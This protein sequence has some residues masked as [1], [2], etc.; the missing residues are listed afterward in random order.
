MFLSNA[1][2]KRPVAM[3]CLLIGLALLG[4]N[5][6]RKLGLELMPALDAPFITV[7][8]LYPGASPGQIEV[9]V[10][11]PIEDA[12]VAIDGLKHVSS[13]CME[14]ICLT[15][16][17][18]ELEVDVDIAATD[19]REKIDLIRNDF[20]EDVED[21][22][23][24]KYDFNSKPVVQL[25]LTGDVP[26]D[27]L[28]DYAD[29]TLKDRLTVLPGVA[30]A[31]LIGGAE[32]EVQVLLDR[33]KLAA[34]NLASSQILE[35]VGRAVGT[36]PSGRIRDGVEEYSVEFDADVARP[37]DLEHLEIIN[38]DGRRCYVRDVARV[39][40]FTEEL[41]Q[42][43]TIDGRPCIAIKVVK[44]SDANAVRVV[45]RV[46]GAMDKLNAELPGGME[47]I[48]VQDDGRF[49]EASVN[50]AWKNVL[51][52]IALTAL[53]LLLF[54]YNVRATLVVA[55]T[56]PL[57][58]VI[59]LFFMQAIGY[60]LNTS[61]LI[62]VGLSVGVL[63]TNS[64]VVL[65]AIVKRLNE[66]GDPKEAARLGAKE[67]SV[68]VL[69]SV[70]TNIVVLF[71]IALMGGMVGQ[72]LSPLAMTMVVMTAV[73]LFISFTL[74]PLLCSLLLKPENGASRSPLKRMERL[75][76]RMF[77][78]VIAAY[79]WGLRLAMRRRWAAAL[80]VVIV[81]ALSL[82]SLPMAKGAGFSL[83]GDT[84]MGQ[85]LV[86]LEFPTR[87][88]LTE[89]TRRVGE[90]EGSLSTLPELEHVLTSIGRVEGVVGQS[91]EGVYLAQ[92]LLKLTERDERSL[93]IDDLKDQVRQ[94]LTS[95]PDCIRTVST[96]SIIGGQDSSIQLQILGDDLDTLDGLALQAAEFAR[97]IPG[98][99]DADTTVRIGKP[100][101]RVTPDRAVLGDLD[102]PA[103]AVGLALRANVEGMEAGTFKERAR[104]Y[105]IVVKFDERQ[106]KGQVDE[107]LFPA[108]G[109]RRLLLD[110]LGQTEQTLA[111]VQI[112]REDKRRCAK[113]LGDNDAS[114]PLGTAVA[115][116]SADMDGKADVPLGYEYR[117]DGPAEA[118]AESMVEFAEAGLIAV[119]LTILTLA[120]ILESFRQPGLI[121]VTIPLGLVGIFW[122]LGLT[123]LS[124]SMFVIMGA[125]M[126]IGIVV[127]NAILIMDQFNFLT[128]E[129]HLPEREAMIQAAGDRLRPIMMI[130]IAAVLGMLPLALG[131]GIGAEMR[132][133]VGVACVGGILVSGLLT[134]VLMPVL[135]GLGPAPRLAS[136][137]SS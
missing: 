100:K 27:E 52:G 127:N 82:A 54:L 87:Y 26:L 33:D 80:V 39:E 63:V 56:M 50:S 81:G 107:F 108:A 16:L 130:T 128:R 131:R 124:F 112:T 99:T 37:E 120:A 111:P 10:A 38:V 62:A 71:P 65:E 58:I 35:A 45:G 36:I 113:L 96:P 57:T 59:G 43:A 24:L 78:A 6:Y 11:K 18:F 90:I 44:K 61:T 67:A 74:T 93:T 21:P 28:Y 106:G 79:Q 84:D 72:F 83:L 48:W 32:R 3:S 109:G 53:I 73:S 123:G 117:F 88:N 137:P 25:A 19:V 17:E 49:I 75:W 133:D 76:N 134:P 119:V 105:D 9:D 4:I 13:S 66:C 22:R 5:S 55:I 68:A 70:G 20:P 23:I 115:L 30:E 116:L 122:A 114:L 125:I 86:K 132:V 110:S 101:I 14:D 126:L 129:K 69:A 12:V 31:T 98:V 97:A 118:L 121:L 77:D 92:V 41:R 51:Q 7:N 104:N 29:N 91:S 34:R 1:A 89:T 40:M 60:T 47:L 94:R 103:T 15:F 8:T 135:Y 102:V 64:I 2:V 46:Q 95:L 42:A 85:I 136:K